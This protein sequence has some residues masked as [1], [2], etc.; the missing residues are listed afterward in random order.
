[1]RVHHGICKCS[2]NISNIS[3]WIHPLHHSALSPPSPHSWNNFNRYHFS[4][5]IHVYIVFE[6]YSSF[7]TFSTL[8]PPSYWYQTPKVGHGLPS[9]FCKRNKNVIF[10]YLG[11]YTGSFLVIFPCIH[12]NITQ[13]GSSNLFFST[14]VLFLWWLQQV[15]KFYIHSCIQSTSTIFTCLT[16]FLIHF[17]CNILH[18]VKD[19]MYL[20][21]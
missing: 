7:H 13:I 3:Y 15:L 16:S 21:N 12:Y 9:S 18:L 6:L 5:Y 11:S 2:Y 4:I 10:V 14:I 17:V 20:H 8:P 1:M 19:L